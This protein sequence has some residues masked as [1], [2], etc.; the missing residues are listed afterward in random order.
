MLL[1]VHV[2]PFDISH[3]AMSL[4]NTI[5]Y[6][7]YVPSQTL[8]AAGSCLHHVGPHTAAVSDCGCNT[9][10]PRSAAMREVSKLLLLLLLLLVVVVLVLVLG[11]V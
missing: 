10:A 8:S 1:A 3:V 5:M 9:T 2:T 6:I 11:G 7:Q 4:Y